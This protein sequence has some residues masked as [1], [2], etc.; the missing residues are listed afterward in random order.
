M[1]WGEYMITEKQ[2]QK[3]IRDVRAGANG[4]NVLRDGGE[5]GAGRLVLVLALRTGGRVSAEWYAYFHRHGERG[6]S[7]LRSLWSSTTR[8]ADTT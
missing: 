6:S 8:P 3:A 1:G 2:I 7:A 5:R 4:S